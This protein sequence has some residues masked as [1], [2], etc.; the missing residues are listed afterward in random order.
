MIL[1]FF[2]FMTDLQIFRKYLQIMFDN[3][4]LHGLPLKELPGHTF[5]VKYS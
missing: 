3:I 5:F 2:L 1:V 4:S